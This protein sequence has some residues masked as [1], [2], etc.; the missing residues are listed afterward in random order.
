M[1]LQSSL[2]SCSELGAGIDAAEMA[3]VIV[4]KELETKA[5]DTETY[6]MAQLDADILVFTPNQQLI[7]A[8]STSIA[9]TYLV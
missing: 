7:L 2:W 6:S 5:P 3:S 4:K 9:I 1:A 8:T